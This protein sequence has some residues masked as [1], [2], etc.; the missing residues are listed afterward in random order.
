MVGSKFYIF[1]GQRDDGAFLNDLVWFDLQKCQY[2]FKFSRQ[3]GLT[4]VKR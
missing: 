4:M 3:F 1:G 2:R